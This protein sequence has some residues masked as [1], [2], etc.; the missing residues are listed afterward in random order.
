MTTSAIPEVDAAALDRRAV[1]ST[2]RRIVQLP[3][4]D[5]DR[6][7]VNARWDVRTLI[8]HLVGGNLLYAKVLCGQ[9]ADWSTRDSREITSPLEQF[10]DSADELAA[11]LD[12]LDD[13]KRPVLTPAGNIPAM[14][15]VAI[16][17]SDMLVHG[18]DLAVATGQDRALDPDLCRAAI[19]IIDRFPAAA[20]GDPRFYAERKHTASVDPVDQLVAL[21]G[22]DP[23][24]DR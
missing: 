10:D 21:T 19:V 14:W 5:L 9:D 18:W 11:A 24:A 13:P 6:A 12:A 1:A 2:R 8:A 4:A 22:R 15:A 3:P 7:T 20:W 16:H 17:A 23:S